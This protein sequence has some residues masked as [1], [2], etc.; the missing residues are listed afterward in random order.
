MYSAIKVNGKK[1]YEY[2]REGKD[3]ERTE[4]E[5]EIYSINIE[6][7]DYE[8]N[9]MIFRVSCSKG[10]Y[11][12]TLC[13]TIAKL[14]GTVGFMKELQR[15]KIDNYKIEDSIKISELEA[16]EN[17]EKFIISIEKIFE[18]CE[19]IELNNRKKELFLNGV[20]LTQNV[21]SGIYRIYSNLEFLGLGTIENNLLK[22]DVI[23]EK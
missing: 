4:R 9:E 16:C 8:K 17:K 15:T 18:K 20:K 7:L 2:A 3:I 6:K 12:R 19:K 10:T 14:F 21:N 13:E 22:R 23:I 1:L 11:I 5:I